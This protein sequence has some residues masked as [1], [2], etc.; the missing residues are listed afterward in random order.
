MFAQ[1]LKSSCKL[2]SV[3]F[4]FITSYLTYQYQQ[5][6][7][8]KLDQRV[9]Q[10]L[11]VL[12]SWIEWRSKMAYATTES[13]LIKYCQWMS[14]ST[15]FHKMDLTS[16][17]IFLAE[18][19]NTTF[20]HDLC[21]KMLSSIEFP[22]DMDMEYYLRKCD[23]TTLIGLARSSDVNLKWFSDMAIPRSL[24][25]ENTSLSRDIEA[26]IQEIRS[27]LLTQDNKGENAQECSTWLF[28]QVVNEHFPDE[29][30][31]NI[32]N[33]LSIQRD[34]H[35][36]LSSDPSEI[37]LTKHL[38]N[39]LKILR[40]YSVNDNVNTNPVLS[41]RVLQIVQQVISLYEDDDKIGKEKYGILEKCGN[42]VANLACTDANRAEIVKRNY[43]PL[44]MRW[45]G[46]PNATLQIVADR[47]LANLDSCSGFENGM[48]RL[49]D[50]IYVLHPNCRSRDEAVVD[51]VFIHGIQGSPFHTWRQGEGADKALF[52]N[53]WPKDWLPADYP[54]IRVICVQYESV[55]SDWFLSCPLENNKRSVDNQAE[56]IKQKLE[57][58]GVGERPIIWVAHSL[59]GLIAK[60]MLSLSNVKTD[61]SNFLTST[62]GLVFY[63]VPHLGSPI[64]TQTGRARFVLFPSKEV[65][66]VEQNSENLRKLHEEFSV[67]AKNF[68]IDCLDFGE[69]KP[70]KIPYVKYR[71]LIVPPDSSNVGYGRFMLLD[72]N[73]QEV[74]KPVSKV[75]PRYWEVSAMIRK[76]LQE[77]TKVQR[78]DFFTKLTISHQ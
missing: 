58:C 46:S 16:C 67:L 4:G 60:R 38:E 71:Q 15:L 56:V 13:L 61:A 50:G 40:Q 26:V 11:D 64:A 42:I 76:V 33:D 18:N 24:L 52:T 30:I 23:H 9:N 39:Y 2:I 63:S 19:Q 45:K 72:T 68:Q 20:M 32:M 28:Q 47:A 12:H 34:H 22:K 62:K 21:I 51:V 41:A 43:L 66:E 25:D 44:L 48:K 29:P 3:S 69:S 75:D 27:A 70:Y 17:L 55:F 53:C 14:K 59:G 65:S 5:T 57:A 54:N 77:N 8:D 37:P 36:L 35:S 31:P 7:G 1:R 78:E 6:F 74:C 49:C 10:N 73:H